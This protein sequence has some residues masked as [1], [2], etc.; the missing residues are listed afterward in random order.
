METKEERG[1]TT[2]EETER[3]RVS[4]DQDDDL[5]IIDH[6]SAGNGLRAVPHADKAHQP[7]LN[8]ELKATLEEMNRRYR[9]Q[10]ERA[11]AEDDTPDAA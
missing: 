1:I 2:G 11:A 3:A 6:L 4:D 8:P 7:A 9:V 10:R 5:D